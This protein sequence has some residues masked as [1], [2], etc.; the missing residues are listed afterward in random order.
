MSAVTLLQ[1]TLENLVSHPDEIRITEVTGDD[2]TVLEVRV[3]EDD[4]G[5][6]IGKGGSVARALRTII[7]GVSLKEDRNFVVEIVD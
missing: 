3:H 1:Y 6:V 2:E 4:I 5:K 7:G